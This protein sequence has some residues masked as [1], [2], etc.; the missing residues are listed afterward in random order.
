MNKRDLSYDDLMGKIS[1][2]ELAQLATDGMLAFAT[3]KRENLQALLIGND[4]FFVSNREEVT[5]LAAKARLPAMYG[6]REFVLVGGLMSYG[7]NLAELYRDKARFV[8][9]ILK[10]ASAGDLPI[11]RP[12]KFELL[13]N[14][15]AA[16]ALGLTFS[17][18]FLATTDEVVE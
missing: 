9:K 7:T 8:D 6:I 12:T 1:Q 18:S 3:S 13:I 17:P 15:K 2:A 5:N 10:G 14:L 16:K 11:E 4:P